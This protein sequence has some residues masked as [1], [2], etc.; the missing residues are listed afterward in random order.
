MD[1]R[2]PVHRRHRGDAAARAAGFER[3]GILMLTTFDLDEYV[4]EALRAGA[5]G[6]LLKDVPRAELIDAR[7]HRRRRR[8]AARAG[9]HPPA[10]RAVRA[11]PPTARA[12][13]PSSSE[14]SPRERDTLLRL[15][16]GRSNAEIAGELV[17]SEATVKTHVAGVLRKLDLRDRIQAVVWAYETGSCGRASPTGVGGI[18]GCPQRPSIRAG[19]PQWIGS[20]SP[21]ESTRWSRHDTLPSTA[22]PGLA[23]PAVFGALSR[24]LPSE[25]V[26][27]S[28]PRRAPGSSGT[29]AGRGSQAARAGRVAEELGD[30][31]VAVDDGDRVPLVRVDIDVALAVERDAVGA[32]ERRVLDEERVEAE[33]VR[34]VGRVAAERRDQVAA[35]V[36]LDPP[37]RAACRVGDEQHALAVEREAVG[38]DAPASPGVAPGETPGSAGRR[39]RCWP[40][41]ARGRARSRRRPS[42]RRGRRGP[43]PCRRRRR[44]GSPS[45]RTRDRSRRACRLRT[46]YDRR[47]RRARRRS[48]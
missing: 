18:E 34:R 46:R 6:F 5:S 22:V 15:A 35:P 47:V 16:R 12:R 43:V 48:A 1:V 37:D 29:R 17:V 14:L 44:T 36:D 11:G 41:S 7:T 27:Q 42:G 39:R 31:A 19:R 23:S 30:V 3:L 10:D 8:L 13:R 9:D 20:G 28:V 32:V 21:A 24:R 33:R 40:S 26:V 45:R 4:Y 25:L 38:D 2:M